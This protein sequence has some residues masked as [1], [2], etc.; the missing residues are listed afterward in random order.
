VQNIKAISPVLNS[1]TRIYENFAHP[2]HVWYLPFK[3]THDEINAC[4]QG[5]IEGNFHDQVDSGLCWQGSSGD[6]EDEGFKK[7][8][9][10]CGALKFVSIS[11]GQ[12]T[13]RTATFELVNDPRYTRSSIMMGGSHKMDG[14]FY[15]VGKVSRRANVDRTSP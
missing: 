13:K 12:G 2:V 3:P 14:S 7:L 6:S 1:Q 10:V 5:L 4:V 15:P 9:E 11:G 8:V